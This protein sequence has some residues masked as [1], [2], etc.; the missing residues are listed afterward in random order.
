MS[1]PQRVSLSLGLLGL[2]MTAHYQKRH[3]EIWCNLMWWQ[4]MLETLPS[5]DRIWFSITKITPPQPHIYSAQTDRQTDAQTHMC[6]CPSICQCVFVIWCV[7]L[8]GIIKGTSNRRR[9]ISPWEEEGTVLEGLGGVEK[10]EESAKPPAMFTLLRERAS[11]LAGTAFSNLHTFHPALQI[12]DHTHKHHRSCCI[13]GLRQK[14][15]V[16]RHN[17]FICAWLLLNKSVCYVCIS[18]V[19]TCPGT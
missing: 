4:S 3:N 2:L 15:H 9:F 12:Y 11:V 7:S 8:K 17:E 6:V 5:T 18:G 19:C 1:R 16:S 14:K 13:V 10:P